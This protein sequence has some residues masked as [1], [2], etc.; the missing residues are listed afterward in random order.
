MPKSVPV[1]D[2]PAVHGLV[3]VLKALEVDDQ[4]VRQDLDAV[5]FHRVHLQPL[6]LQLRHILP[7]DLAPP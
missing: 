4:H 3:V 6:Q 2:F 7:P 1:L 5:A